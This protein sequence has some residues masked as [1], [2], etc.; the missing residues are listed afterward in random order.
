M[1]EIEF[2]KYLG[3]HGRLQPK[4]CNENIQVRRETDAKSSGLRETGRHQIT[5]EA[6][7]DTALTGLCAV[8]QRHITNKDTRPNNDKTSNSKP[9]VL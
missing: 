1:L 9:V 2:K 3:F 4:P 5:G 8:H 6:Q 7:H